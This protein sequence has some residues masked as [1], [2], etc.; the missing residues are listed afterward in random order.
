MF[1]STIIGHL[2]TRITSLLLLIVP[3]LKD[4]GQSV[5]LSIDVL[6]VVWDKREL[7]LL[8]FRELWIGLVQPF[9]K[10]ISVYLNTNQ[11]GMQKSQLDVSIYL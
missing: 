1:V 10:T 3:S 4:E 2:S 7:P 9:G 6:I 8:C 11:I 5:R